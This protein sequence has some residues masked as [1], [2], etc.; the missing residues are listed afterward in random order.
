MWVRWVDILLA[1]DGNIA[2]CD[3]MTK[4]QLL[5]QVDWPVR[6]GLCQQ[7]KRIAAGVTYDNISEFKF[8]VL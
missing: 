4:V 6:I 1:F 2:L 3:M 7:R 5:S 8:F